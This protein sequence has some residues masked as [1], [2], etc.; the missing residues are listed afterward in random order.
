MKRVL[1]GM[2]ELLLMLECVGKLKITNIEFV[3]PDC[4]VKKFFYALEK[5]FDNEECNST[6]I[7]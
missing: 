3:E 7:S 2:F 6:P 5:A 1:T 4:N